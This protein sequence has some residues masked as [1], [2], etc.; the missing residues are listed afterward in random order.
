MDIL[1]T[2]T[3]KIVARIWKIMKELVFG[4]VEVQVP[5]RHPNEAYIIRN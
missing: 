3:C 4:H 2:F 1:E 5:L